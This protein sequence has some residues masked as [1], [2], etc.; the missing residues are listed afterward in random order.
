[1]QK[2]LQRDFDAELEKDIFEP[3][4]GNESLHKIN[5]DNGVRA[6]NFGTSKNQIVKSIQCFYI[7]TFINTFDYLMMGRQAN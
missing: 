3:T 1:M 4:S 5:N 7:V 6:V 2:I